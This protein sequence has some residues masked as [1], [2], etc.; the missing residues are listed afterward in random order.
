MSDSHTTMERP[1]IMPGLFSLVK[2]SASRRPDIF[3]ERF[4]LMLVF[5]DA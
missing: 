1:G 4:L 2:K 3:L 5:A